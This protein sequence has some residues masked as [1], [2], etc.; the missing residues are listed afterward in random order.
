MPET[1]CTS[2]RPLVDLGDHGPGY[3]VA[4]G[5]LHLALRV[6]LHEAPVPAFTR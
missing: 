6:A 4:R 2:P 1:S 3:D 5:E